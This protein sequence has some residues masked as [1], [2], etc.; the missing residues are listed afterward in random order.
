[1][2]EHKD[3]PGFW[4]AVLVLALLAGL[5][6][7]SGA[8]LYD[9]GFRFEWGD[10]RA[11]GVI[12]VLSCGIMLSLLMSYKKMGYRDLFNPTR[13]SIAS[14]IFVLVVPIVLTVGGGVF[15]ITDLTNLMLLFFP[16]NESEYMALTRLL[17]GGVV[18][19]IS[20][21]L[22]A[23]LIEEMLFRGVI[24]R[25]FLE[26]YSVGNAVLLSSLLFALFHMTVSQL[27]V[28]FIVGCFLGWLYVRTRS[29]WPSIMGHFLYNSFAM[30]LWFTYHSSGSDEGF[31]PEFN[32]IFV[33]A[34]ALTSSAI[35]VAMLYRILHP[36]RGGLENDGE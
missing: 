2:E 6:I 29:L 10:P 30:L 14:I 28:A 4:G 27:P 9:L 33:M 5:Q 7:I 12:T 26:N 31:S 13:N 34:A 32:S 36:R 11:G 1:M 25:A 19:L 15:W 21:C 18:S 17:D 20:T 8:F 35:G 24:L 22:I 16:V 23:P 3:F